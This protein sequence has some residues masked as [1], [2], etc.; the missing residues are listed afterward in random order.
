VNMAT[1]KRKRLG[2]GTFVQVFYNNGGCVQRVDVWGPDGQWW[3]AGATNRTAR[4]VIYKPEKLSATRKNA[5]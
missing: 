3:S 2:E 5:P 4:L 1:K